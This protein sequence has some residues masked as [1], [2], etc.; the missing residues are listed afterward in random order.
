MKDSNFPAGNLIGKIG[1]F[2]GCGERFSC[3]MKEVRDVRR[4]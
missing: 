2:R 3:S 1:F 4:P